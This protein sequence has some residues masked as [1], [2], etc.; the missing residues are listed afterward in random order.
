[1][2]RTENGEFLRRIEADTA[3]YDE[4]EKIWIFD[5]CRIFTADENGDINMEKINGYRN[6]AY[7]EFP[8]TFRNIIKDVKELEIKPARDWIRA[9]K[10]SGLPYRE[11]LTDFHQRFSFALTPFIV[12]LISCAMGG[13]FKKNILLMSLLFSLGLAS[14]YYILQMISVLLAK[15]GSITPLMGA[16]SGFFLFFLLGLILF[17]KART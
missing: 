10:R 7:N 3:K 9:L 2:E 14:F 15:L 17:R 8:E 12:T 4:E 5:N 13:R 1:M 6:E 11:A 16:W